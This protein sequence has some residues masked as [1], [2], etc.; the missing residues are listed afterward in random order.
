MFDGL[1]GL[2]AGLAEALPAPDEDV[3]EVAEMGDAED[4]VGWEVGVSEPGG[5]LG[6]VFATLVGDLWR[7][8]V[9]VVGL[10]MEEAHLACV[11]LGSFVCFATLL[12]WLRLVG[13]KDTTNI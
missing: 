5:Y 3:A 13:L 12:G 6:L 10:E 9:R 11:S 1:S 2:G 4:A 8:T 7:C